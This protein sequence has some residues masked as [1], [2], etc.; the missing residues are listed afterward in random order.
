MEKYSSYKDSGVQWLGEI[1]SHWEVLRLGS[2]FSERKEKVSDKDYEPLSVTKNGIFPQLDNVAKTKDGD[3]RK[4]VRKNDFVINSRSDRKG[5][6]G[7]SKYDGSVSLI[8]IVLEPRK[9]L[10]PSFCNYLLKS[11][12]F[13]EEFYR[14]GHGIVADLWTTRYDEMKQIKVAFPPLEEQQSMASYLDKATAEIDKAIAQQQHMID[15]LNERKQIIIQRAVTRGLDENVEMKDSELSW[16][17]HIPSHWELIRLGYTSWIRARLGWR[18]LKA[19]EYVDSGYAFL[20]AFNIVNNKMQW[21]KVNFI[22]KFRY[23]E[24]PEIKLNIGDI[25]LVKDGAGIGKCARVDEL[26]L[27]EATANGSLAFITPNQYLDYRFLHYFIICDSFKKYT[28]LLLTGMG[29]PHFTQGAMKKV[30][31][32]IPPLEEQKRIIFHLDEE[33]GKFDIAIGRL[34]KQISLLQERKQIIISEVVT[35]KIKVS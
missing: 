30:K 22:N 29:V 35:G 8:N 6:S 28:E 31:V 20:S 10:E 19:N 17:G 15:L 5:S 21:D 24:S 23:D 1:P 3:N 25:L 27:G 4:L 33:V 34:E 13:I 16:L 2:Y 9:A 32:P 7:V 26:P 12:E 14:N 11:T 18:G